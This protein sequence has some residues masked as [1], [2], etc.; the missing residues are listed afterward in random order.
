MLARRLALAALCSLAASLVAGAGAAPTAAPRGTLVFAGTHNGNF[1]IYSVRADGSRLGQLTHTRAQDT[2]PL[3]SPDG[4]RILFLRGTTYV[5]VPQLALWVMNADGSRQQ[6]LASHGADPAWS[7][8]SRRIAYVGRG[9]SP[10]VSFLVVV[11]AD[12]SNRLVIAGRKY[13]PVWS[14]DSKRLALAT[15]SVDERT[16]LAVVG[17]DGRGLRTIRRNIGSG[18]IAWLPSGLISFGTNDGGIDVVRPDGRHARRLRQARRVSDF[19]WA[20]DGRRFA[21]TDY[22]GSRLYV[23][24]TA[25]RALRDVTP[26]RAGYSLR[27]PAWSPDGRWVAVRHV[28][29][30]TDLGTYGDLLVVAADGSSWREIGS[31]SS[32][33]YR[34]DSAS[35]SWRP[36]GAT[37]ARLGA[38][39]AR[40]SPSETR[41]RTL[42][43]TAGPVLGLA[44]D[45][46]RVAVSVDW[47]S[48]DCGHVAVWAPGGG[49][50]HVGWQQPCSQDVGAAPSI[51]GVLALAAT[52]VAW[53]E[54]GSSPSTETDDLLSASTVRPAKVAEVDDAESCANCSSGD[55][56]AFLSDVYGDGHLLAYS[57]WTECVPTPPDEG[58]SDCVPNGEPVGGTTI[59]DERLWRIQGA[60]RV[61]VRSGTGLVAPTGVDA[62]RIVILEIGGAVAV[63]HASGS[64]VHRLVLPPGQAVSAQLSGSQLLVLTATGL[65]AYDAA[66]GAPEKTVSLGA[67]TNRRLADFDK[68]IAVYVEGRTVHVLRLAN[69]RR[70]SFK[71]LGKGQVVAQLEPSG[72]FTGYTLGGG[73]RPG[74]VAFL[75][76]AALDRRLGS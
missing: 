24:S 27:E 9:R 10:D 20:P 66:T 36:A 50:V 49:L 64:L 69:Q 13:S 67:S 42:L 60:K 37:P 17:A 12:G 68:G 8:D 7:P 56:G 33:P 14:P 59:K 4:R 15:N 30:S 57:S 63:L 51:T 44:A 5:R 35:P 52:R 40:P 53:F 28:L 73:T 61:L 74:R 31:P 76:R 38:R 62:G 71:L 16:D 45:G 58:T 6:K 11:S 39:P 18:P 22:G 65:Q 75:T 55:Q 21:F 41:S 29:A 47:S 2:A 54:S 43:R 25:R 23:G 19:A 46:N 48:I 26:K 70:T 1:G 32:F 72:L 3:F 34:G